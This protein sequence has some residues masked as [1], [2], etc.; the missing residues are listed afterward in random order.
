M[1]IVPGKLPAVVASMVTVLF[2]ALVIRSASSVLE[3]AVPCDQ[4]VL[5]SHLSEPSVQ[6]L[7]G[8]RTTTPGADVVDAREE[9]HVATAR[10]DEAGVEHR[11]VEPLDGATGGDDVA[12]VA[13][14]SR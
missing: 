1:V 9:L 12:V 2:P 5:V 4:F 8:V 7:V 13:H 10:V 3:G 11:A 14:S 6:L